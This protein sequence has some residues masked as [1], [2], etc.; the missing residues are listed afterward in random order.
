MCLP[1]PT[2]VY[3]L[4]Q[5]MA[6]SYTQDVNEAFWKTM[7]RTHSLQNTFRFGAS[8]IDVDLSTTYSD[9]KMNNQSFPFVENSRLNM[10]QDSLIYRDPKDSF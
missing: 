5:D 10:N 3:L 2:S 9:V 4:L 8:K 7:T 6:A 1:G